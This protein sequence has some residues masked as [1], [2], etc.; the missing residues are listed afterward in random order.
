M[1]I[2]VLQIGVGPI[3][4][5]VANQLAARKAFRLVGAVDTDP[6]KIGRDLGEIAEIG[7]RLRIKIS[8]DLGRAIQEAKPGIAVQPPPR[9]A[10]RRD[11]QEGV[12]YV[13]RVAK[14]CLRLEAYPYDSVLIEGSPLIYSKVQ[15]GIHGDIA[16][17]S[18]R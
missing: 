2:P 7:R 3:G 9:P 12:G 11:G 18:S 10:H 13:G 4:R 1:T 15:G 16:T 6:G 8:D 14:I 17:A 5:A